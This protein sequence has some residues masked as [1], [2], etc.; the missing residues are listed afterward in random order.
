MANTPLSKQHCST[1][2]KLLM[3]GCWTA[4]II[5]SIQLPVHAQ[6]STSATSA[7][8]NDNSF[9][10][11]LRN[12]VTGNVLDNDVNL[13]MPAIV[14]SVSGVIPAGIT[15][16]TDGEVSGTTALTGTFVSE[17]QVTDATGMI[18]TAQLTIIIQ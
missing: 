14:E 6:T 1:R 5:Y 10:G 7:T 18:G 15:L 16:A 12:G 3:A 2:R 4:P 17:Y 9:I 13:T 8:L 11:S